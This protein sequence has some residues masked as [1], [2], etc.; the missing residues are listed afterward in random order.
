[1]I[2]LEPFGAI[3]YTE[4]PKIWKAAACSVLENLPFQLQKAISFSFVLQIEH[5]QTLWTAE[6]V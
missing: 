2:S 3:R 4:N 5:S 6:D 1:M